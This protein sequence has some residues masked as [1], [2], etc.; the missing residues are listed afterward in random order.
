M[1][2]FAKPFKDFFTEKSG[3]KNYEE[4]VLQLAVEN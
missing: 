3:I 2:I 4:A 1:G